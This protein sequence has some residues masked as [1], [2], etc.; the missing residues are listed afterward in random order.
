MIIIHIREKKIF[1]KKRE[2]NARARVRA[3][4]GKSSYRH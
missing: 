3:R 1:N 2:P 4:I